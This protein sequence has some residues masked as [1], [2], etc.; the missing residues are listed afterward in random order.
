[1][2]A[3]RFLPLSA[4]LVVCA[5]AS[6]GQVTNLDIVDFGD[7]PGVATFASFDT[8]AMETGGVLEIDT[9]AF[10]GFFVGFGVTDFDYNEVQVRVRARLL[11]GNEAENFTVAFADEDGTAPG[12]EPM[13]DQWGYRFP[14]TGFTETEFRDVVLPL[15]SV[16][17]PVGAA[18]GAM[19]GDG[20]PNFGFNLFL[21]QSDFQ[22]RDRLAIEIE[23][24]A[25]EPICLTATYYLADFGTGFGGGGF[26]SFAAG[27]VETD[28]SIIYM[29]NDFGGGGRSFPG[30][31]TDNVPVERYR[32]RITGRRLA[33]NVQDN[34]QLIIG[35]IDGDRS[36]D[37]D[38]NGADSYEYNFLTEDFAVGEFTDVSVP[39]LDY[40][41]GP[42]QN[43]GTMF[44]GDGAFNPGFFEWFIQS[45]FGETLAFNF[46]IKEIVLEPILEA[47]V[48]TVVD[49][50]FDTPSIPGLFTFG[51]FNEPNALMALSDSITIDV[52]NSGEIGAPV[53][54]FTA[55]EAEN[56]A[57]EV[58]AR[59]LVGN[60]ATNFTIQLTDDDTLPGEP[61]FQ[62]GEVYA[63]GFSLADFGAN[64]DGSVPSPQ[65]GFF[66]AT[67]PLTVP[68]PDFRQ[69]AF[70]FVEDGDMIQNYGFARWQLGSTFGST[71]RT[72][73]EVDSIRLLG[74]APAYIDPDLDGDGERTFFDLLDYL[75]APFDLTGEG[76][77]DAEDTLF[78][79]NLQKCACPS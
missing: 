70:G 33:G 3:Q 77:V 42:N 8:D 46:E 1:M 40:S 64:P 63:F 58:T 4:A 16:P 49:F 14:T 23:E 28:D 24:I 20:I 57:L 12:G 47:P 7:A 34:F 35:D 30:G 39:L 26:G 22:V 13:A 50:D 78:F 59:A 17:F 75:A 79:L 38:G 51:S 29:V 68:V 66:T 71:L 18:P 72:Y 54:P 67:R 74:T 10:G 62:R 15:N 45:P 37:M 73:L 43:F 19:A 52:A 36:D 44:N 69:R 9:E 11:P 41:S 61:A 5:S 32:V 65:P 60:Q 31:F 53:N 55:F 2:S 76:V 25:I 21:L 27:A 56:F 6:V 48:I